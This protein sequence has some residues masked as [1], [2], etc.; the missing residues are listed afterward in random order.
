MKYLQDYREDKQTDLFNR[1]GSFFAFSNKQFDEQKKEGAIYVNCGSGLVCEK[2]HVQT[3]IDELDQ[4]NQQ[5]IAQDLAD[6]GY[7]N[8]IA[9]ELGN[10]E[11]YYT[12]DISDAVDEL[13]QYG[14]SRKEVYAV[15]QAEK[16]FN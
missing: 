6:N 2:Q 16:R 11:C 7:Y 3:L 8:I 4:I 10:Y 9:R 13:K 12:G 14:I 1:T 15:Y 5:A